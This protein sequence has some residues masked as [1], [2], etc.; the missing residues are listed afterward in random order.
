MDVKVKDRKEEIEYLRIACNM[1]ELGLDYIHADLI[2]RLQERLKKLKGKF[3]ISDSVEIH[4][5]WKEDWRK[6]FEQQT[7]QK[8]KIKAD[9]Q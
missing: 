2:I 1:A 6:Y 5:K 8:V 7:E 9:K 3:S 4:Y